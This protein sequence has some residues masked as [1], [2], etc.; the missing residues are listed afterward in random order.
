[1]AR[2]RPTMEEQFYALGQKYLAGVNQLSSGT[3]SAALVVFHQGKMITQGNR[4]ITETVQNHQHEIE[5]HPAILR[6]DINIKLPEPPIMTRKQFGYSKARAWLSEWIPLI[7]G[8]PRPGYKDDSNRPR[9][10]SQEI[11][12]QSPNAGGL[13][14]NQFVK[15]IMD[16]YTANGHDPDTLQVELDVETMPMQLIQAD[17]VIPVANG[18]EEENV[19]DPSEPGPSR[20][21]VPTVEHNEPRQTQVIASTQTD[22]ITPMEVSAPEPQERPIESPNVDNTA[23]PIL[24]SQ[25][26]E[27]IVKAREEARKK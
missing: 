6:N 22:V 15:L 25:M 8:R 3:A 12:F 11:P 20:E 23:S 1:M 16:I 24:I 9:W 19:D 4:A 7:M 5:D 13:S 21:S 14:R 2:S 18:Q 26:R 10:W 27:R 17:A